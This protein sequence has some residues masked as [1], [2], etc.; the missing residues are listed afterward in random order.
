MK[1]YVQSSIINMTNLNTAYR[2]TDRLY[3]I[4]EDGF[5]STVTTKCKP[6]FSSRVH[7]IRKVCDRYTQQ[8]S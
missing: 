1:E 7:E 4:V 5:V 2:K 8:N 3:H 6:G